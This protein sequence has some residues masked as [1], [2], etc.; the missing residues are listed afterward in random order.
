M[1]SKFSGKFLL[2]KISAFEIVA[3][4]SVIMIRVRVKYLA[5]GGNGLT[6]S[7]EIEDL[8]IRDVS[9]NYVN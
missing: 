2:F 7:P 9:Q 8:T 5:L 6:Y 1:E 4:F 3:L